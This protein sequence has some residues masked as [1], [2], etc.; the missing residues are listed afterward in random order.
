MLG[1][2]LGDRRLVVVV[3]EKRNL[4]YDTGRAVIANALVF[5]SDVDVSRTL[6]SCQPR[7]SLGSF[8]GVASS[9]H[10]GPLREGNLPQLRRILQNRTVVESADNLQRRGAQR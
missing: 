6:G 3:N 9:N 4:D 7:P 8:Q 2:S 5:I 1:V 10:I